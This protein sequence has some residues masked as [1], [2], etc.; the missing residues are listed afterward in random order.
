M[1]ESIEQGVPTPVLT[2]ALQMRFASQDKEGYPYR[3]LSMMRNAFGGHAVKRRENKNDAAL[4]PG[5]LRRDRQFGPPQTDAF[6][7]QLEEAGRLPDKMVIVAF[8][9][10]PWDRDEWVEEVAGMLREKWGEN[11]HAQ[12]FARFKERLHY[13]QGDLHDGRRWRI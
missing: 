12:T 1:Q 2:L 11:F 7:L 13:L 9:R 6:T 3:L 5:D 10:R 4:Q 8:G